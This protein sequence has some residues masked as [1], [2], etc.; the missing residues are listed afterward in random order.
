MHTWQ[1][2]CP[3]SKSILRA[4]SPCIQRGY[5]INHARQ[6]SSSQLPP[7]DVGPG[8]WKESCAKYQ[9][10]PCFGALI[11]LIGP[12]GHDTKVHRLL[13]GR[14]CPRS[15]HARPPPPPN[16]FRNPRTREHAPRYIALRPQL[17]CSPP[18]FAP[19]RPNPPATCRIRSGS[20]LQ[21][22]LRHTFQGAC[23]MQATNR[24]I[25]AVLAPLLMFP[26]PTTLCR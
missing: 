2:S 4:S 5:R 13:R 8:R 6:V 10:H 18:S 25:R 11:R 22:R 17:A 26:P 19:P 14:P 24:Q 23:T 16:S 12:P 7:E 9:G 1:R 21:R 15:V 3:L 20:G